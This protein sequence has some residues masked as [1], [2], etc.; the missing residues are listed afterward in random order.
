MGVLSLHIYTH[1]LYNQ[2]SIRQNMKWV[3][4]NVPNAKE[5]REILGNMLQL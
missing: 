5:Q 1:V 3:G 2:R 4:K